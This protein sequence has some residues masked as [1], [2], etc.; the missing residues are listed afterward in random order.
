[1]PSSTVRKDGASVVSPH[2]VKVIRAGSS[3]TSRSASCAVSYSIPSSFCTVGSQQTVDRC[4]VTPASASTE[5][6]SHRSSVCPSRNSVSPCLS[7]DRAYCD[8]LTTQ[9]LSASLPNT[10]AD[11]CRQ[12]LSAVS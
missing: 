9:T 5:V 12:P 11:A 3:T 6:T 2:G 8:P 7:E 1:M 4:P 10:A